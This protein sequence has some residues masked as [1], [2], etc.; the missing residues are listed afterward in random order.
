MLM[1]SRLQEVIGQIPDRTDAFG[2]E[3]DIEKRERCP[4]RALFRQLV[5]KLAGKDKDQQTRFLITQAR[6]ISRNTYV[7]ITLE[8][9]PKPPDYAELHKKNRKTYAHVHNVIDKVL[10]I[11]AG[12]DSLLSQ[13]KIFENRWE[14]LHK[15]RFM[16]SSTHFK[17]LQT[18]IASLKNPED[19]GRIV[20]HACELI[21]TESKDSN[22]DDGKQRVSPE[23]KRK[24]VFEFLHKVLKLLPVPPKYTSISRKER[25]KYK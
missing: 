20:K 8:S 12:S 9:I 15:E 4:E 16:P 10:P 14:F 17:E 24:I 7:Q 6:K 18:L 23:K 21:P 19:L 25:I 2:D 1:L 11:A 5:A 22:Q 3:S 13:K